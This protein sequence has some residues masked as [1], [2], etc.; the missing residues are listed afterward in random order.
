MDGG[1]TAGNSRGIGSC[2]SLGASLLS[3]IPCIG[4][5][6]AGYLQQEH[7]LLSNWG[8]PLA[9]CRPKNPVTPLPCPSQV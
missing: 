2:F 5:D 4:C 9:S 8:T 7:F 1:G 3:G 6:L